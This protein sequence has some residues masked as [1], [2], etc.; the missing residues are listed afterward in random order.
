MPQ[1]MPLNWF[2]LFSTF[3]LLLITF[4]IMNYF[5]SFNM[6]NIKSSN[7]SSTKSIIWKW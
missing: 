1:M 5:S 3:S 4:N 2:L 7:L 6:Y